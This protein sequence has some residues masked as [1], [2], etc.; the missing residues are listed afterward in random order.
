MPTNQPNTKNNKKTKNHESEFPQGSTVWHNY[1]LYIV[2]KKLDSSPN[3]K[4]EQDE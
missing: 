3:K 1:C 4:G 2:G